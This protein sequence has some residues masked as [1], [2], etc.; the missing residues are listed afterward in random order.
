MSRVPGMTACHRYIT[1]DCRN[2]AGTLG[3]FHEAM[4]DIY[5]EY[6]RTVESHGGSKGVVY[7]LVLTVELPSRDRAYDDEVRPAGSP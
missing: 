2:R 6:V 7:N 4:S 5:D 3:A 1:D